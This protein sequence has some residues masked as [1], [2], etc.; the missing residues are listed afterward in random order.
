MRSENCSI[1]YI[2]PVCRELKIS[3]LKYFSFESAFLGNIVET[4]VDFN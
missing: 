3:E 2:K 4:Q 1:I